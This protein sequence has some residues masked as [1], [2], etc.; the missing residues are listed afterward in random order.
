MGIS[1]VSLN[2]VL[3]VMMTLLDLMPRM[4]HGWHLDEEL[5]EH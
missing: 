1:K 2:L 4:S 3:V 5:D